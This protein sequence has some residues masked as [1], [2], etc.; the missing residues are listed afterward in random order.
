MGNEGGNNEPHTKKYEVTPVGDW[1]IDLDSN[2]LYWSKEVYKI[3]DLPLDYSPTLEEGLQFYHPEDRLIIQAAVERLKETGETYDLELR[4]VTDDGDVYW[5]RTTG[6]PQYNDIGEITK[7]RGVYRDITIEKERQQELAETRRKLETSNQQLKKFASL[8]SHDLRNPLNVAEGRLALAAEECESEHLA[9]VER[10]HSRMEALI[11][12][13]LTLAREGKTV[14]SVESV[15][16]SEIILDSWSVI[17]T[18]NATLEMNVTRTVQTDP[19][20]F[21]QILENLIRNAIDH[22]GDD[23]TI[24]IGD[25][26]GGLYVEDTGPGIAEPDRETVFESG[27]STARDGTGFGLAIVKEITTAHGWYIDVKAGDAGG[28]RFEITGIET[29]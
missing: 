3:R 22:G 16:L 24:R 28:A 23:V 27:Y 11:S 21:Q 5:V 19:A 26:D 12:G 9:V 29:E 20:R 1:E 7:I 17:D 4:E 8:V 2:K 10:A 6:V 14:D 18:G 25:F 15:K 13:I